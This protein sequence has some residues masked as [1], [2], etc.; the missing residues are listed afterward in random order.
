MRGLKSFGVMVVVLIGLGAYLYLV[1]SKKTPG[2]DTPKKDKVFAV[3][4]DK[5]DE[6]TIRSVSGDK[7][8]LKKNGTA[9]A[10]AQPADAKPDDSEVSGITSN[11]ASAEIQRVVEEN[12]ADLKEFGLAEPRIDIAFKAAGKE[13]RLQIGAKTPT[14][15]DLYAKL[16][17]Q[18]RVFLI[19]SFLE[20]TF[21]KST[22]DLRDKAVLKL[23]R[24][25]IDVLEV[26]TPEHE[27]RFQKTNADWTITKPTAVRA[28]F[29]AVDGLVTKLNS[30]Q[31]KAIAAPEAADLKPFGLDKPAA[32]VTLGAGSARATLI[33]GSASPDGTVYAK[34]QSRP[35]VFTI[36]SSILDDLK[37][38]AVE[39]RQKDL[40]D[41]RAF[42]STRIEIVR[43][44]QTV[45]F[46]KTK[47]KDKD[48]KEEEKWRKVLPAPAEADSNNVESLIST[49]AGSR[50][51][52]FVESTAKTGLEKPEVTIAI[53]FDEGKEEKVSF[54]RS[55]SDGYA[56]RTGMPGAAKVDV[57]TIDGIVKAIEAAEKPPAPPAPP[58]LPPA[59]KK[60]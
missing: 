12:P 50:A 48:G 16:A 14:G 53:K 56:S 52:G 24:D 35:A 32:T 5:I 57:A 25:K 58:A 18:K 28:D 8:T 41:A 51:T 15:S 19:P 49:A 39:Y 33:V 9:W 36:E 21:N 17:D 20:S 59:E 29:N 34:D 27:A 31:M 10:I 11:L 40:F 7:T 55:G 45:A 13:Q 2:D 30:A 6:I 46:E 3:E 4:A 54:S 60:K 23:E 44:G 26:T 43:G 38:P 1:E 47:T 42:N 37:K 22:F